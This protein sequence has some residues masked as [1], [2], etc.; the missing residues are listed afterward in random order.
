MSY[1]GWFAWIAA[2]AAAGALSWVTACYLIPQPCKPSC[3]RDRLIL[4]GLFTL[5][6]GLGV[7]LAWRQPSVPHGIGMLVVTPLL[8]AISVIDLRTRRIPDILN[9]ALLAWACIQISW[10]KFPTFL[11]AGIGLL[12]AGGFFLLL[13]LFSRGAMGWGDVKLAGVLGAWLGFPLV[14]IALVIGIL[15]GG[16]AALGLIIAGRGK[17][18]STMAYGPYLALGG[19]IA[20]LGLL[21]G[22]WM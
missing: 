4:A 15:A 14:L 19:W 17:R 3:Q 13:A 18:G 20:A 9:L 12:L 11:D 1:L 16:V 10:L 8:A 6:I 5:G 2:G 7:V 21:L 22:W